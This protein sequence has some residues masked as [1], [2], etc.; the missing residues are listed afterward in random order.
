MIINKHIIFALLL[1]IGSAACA[2]ENDTA[3]KN[4][5]EKFLTFFSPHKRKVE[6][7][8]KR[9]S[10]RD[11]RV[12][13]EVE[14]SQSSF[15]YK[16]SGTNSKLF[17]CDTATRKSLERFERMRTEDPERYSVEMQRRTGHYSSSDYGHS[18]ITPEHKNQHNLGEKNQGD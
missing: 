13:K 6:K 10:E 17:N 18:K 3:N 4:R 8:K 16:R 9:A 5:L 2:M 11:A 12:L 15:A 14:N 1:S 7:E